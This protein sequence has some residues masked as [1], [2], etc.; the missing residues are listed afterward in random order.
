MRFQATKNATLHKG[1]ITNITLR[2]TDHLDCNTR[3]NLTLGVSTV[4]ISKSANHTRTTASVQ[5]ARMTP[6]SY[7]AN[8][9]EPVKIQN[10]S[11]S[12]IPRMWFTA[13]WTMY[14]GNEI[15][16]K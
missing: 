11:T 1:N 15:L 13:P 7:P 10:I 3:P 5:K 9:S 8:V 2:Y 14:N 16:P 12:G 6:A 4:R